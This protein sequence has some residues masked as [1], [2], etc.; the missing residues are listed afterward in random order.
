[1]P[2]CKITFKNFVHFISRIGTKLLDI[3]SG[4]SST[5]LTSSLPL[6]TNPFLKDSFISKK[7]DLIG[8]KFTFLIL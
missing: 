7:R 6:G 5:F 8:L 3:V 2:L 1:M 4:Y